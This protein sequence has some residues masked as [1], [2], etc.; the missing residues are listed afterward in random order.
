[1]SPGIDE[2]VDDQPET[3]RRSEREQN[4]VGRDIEVVVLIEFLCQARG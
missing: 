2:H 3:A 1:M 4:L